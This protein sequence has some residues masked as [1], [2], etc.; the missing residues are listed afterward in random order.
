MVAR[1]ISALRGR[2]CGGTP[3]QS[4]LAAVGRNDFPNNSYNSSYVGSSIIIQFG[5]IR[6]N[7]C[8]LSRVIYQ[9]SRSNF[10]L[11]KGNFLALGENSA[12]LRI[13]ITLHLKILQVLLMINFEAQLLMT[14]II[15]LNC[16]GCVRCIGM[17]SRS[18]TK[19]NLSVTKIL[20]NIHK[21]IHVLS[22]K[23]LKQK[24]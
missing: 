12:Q 3:P 11:G 13:D 24:F 14:L 20:F 22:F 4:I 18:S 10:C 23:S 8:T 19:L 7:G 5:G 6:F 15:F 21:Q 17:I 9:W 16:T 2:P 1:Q